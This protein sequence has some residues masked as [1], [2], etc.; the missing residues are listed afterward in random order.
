ML[1]YW[2]TRHYRSTRYTSRAPSGHLFVSLSSR[3]TLVCIL[4]TQ[5][6]RLECSSLEQLPNTQFYT[7]HMLADTLPSLTL[8]LL[9]VNCLTWRWKHA[10]YREGHLLYLVYT[11]RGRVRMQLTCESPPL[12]GGED[13]C[14]GLTASFTTTCCM[15][16]QRYLQRQQYWCRKQLFQ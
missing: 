5:H 14:C 3:Q 7:A 9:S 8:I 15:W 12:A 13:L 1:W 16:G 2:T 4:H 10:A 11:S 6:T